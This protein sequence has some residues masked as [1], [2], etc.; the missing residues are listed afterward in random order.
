MSETTPV[1]ETVRWNDGA[2]RIL[3][4]RRLPLEEIYVDLESVDELIEA[5]R[6]LA[7]RGAPAI[8]VAGAFGIALA[9]REIDA[10]SIEDLMR[11]LRAKGEALMRARPTAVNLRWAA[12]RVLA[13]VERCA[14]NPPARPGGSGA[15]GRSDRRQPSTDSGAGRGGSSPA[16]P[17]DRL[18]EEALD[19]AERI[20]Q[21]DLAL[22]QAMAAH[23][24]GLLPD[25]GSNPTRVISHCNTGGLATAGGGTALGIVLEGARRGR[26]FF[27]HV[28]E[29]RPLL[30]GARLTTWE[31][32]R[33]G[34]PYAVHC[35]GAAAWLMRT[36]R[37]HACLVGADRIA[38]N[39][40][41]ANKIGTLGL[42]LAA[43][44][45]G[46]PFYVV[47]PRSSFDLSLSGGDAIPIE[48]RDD[49]EVLEW[50]GIRIAPRAGTAWNPAFDVTPA[51]LVT[52][53]V[54][55]RGVEHPPF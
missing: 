30:Q 55:E 6:V 39:G 20:L 40:D 9:A 26:R 5:I 25:P 42:A 18:R 36:E 27:V 51:A 45:F 10:S 8:G 19:E 4:Q 32:E 35:D 24:L 44:A 31:L 38:A 43:R 41:T 16:D 22:S 54:T 23:G 53:W 29:T 21:E 2:V 37:I 33:A 52:A 14:A 50:G 49:R 46:V 28:D 11:E 7:V 15:A 13:R 47:A 12:E 17:L 3:D 48:R 34:V 1:L